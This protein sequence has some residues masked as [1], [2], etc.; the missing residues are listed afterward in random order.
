MIRFFASNLQKEI[1]IIII[2]ET[3]QRKMMHRNHKTGLMIMNG[4]YEIGKKKKFRGLETNRS[5]IDMAHQ[6]NVDKDII[7]CLCKRK[8]SYTAKD[9][10]TFNIIVDITNEININKDYKR[11]WDNKFKIK[12]LLSD[13]YNS[14]PHII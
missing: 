5:I 2:C 3:V 10:K 4:I 13:N 1:C 11:V 6:T 12:D 14:K 8:I 7:K 9:I